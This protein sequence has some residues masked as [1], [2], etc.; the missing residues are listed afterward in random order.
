[1]RDRGE[2]GRQRDSSINVREGESM[3]KGLAVSSDEI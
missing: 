1:M 2:K 3:G